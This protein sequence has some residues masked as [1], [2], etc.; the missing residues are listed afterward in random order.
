MLIAGEN[1]GEDNKFVT[2][3]SNLGVTSNPTY[4]PAESID[5]GGEGGILDKVSDFFGDNPFGRI[6]DKGL[7]AAVNGG[8]IK[9]ALTGGLFNEI[10]QG[11]QNPKKGDIFDGRGKRIDTGS[12]SNLGDSPDG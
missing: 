3:D 11:I 10:T 2:G 6:L 9:D 1:I 5:I 12:D 7:S 8:D 4:T